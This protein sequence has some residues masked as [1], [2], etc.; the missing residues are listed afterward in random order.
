VNP[1]GSTVSGRGAA[2][3]RLFSAAAQPADLLIREAHVLDPRAQID[4][5][6]D[7]LIRGGEIAELAVAGT[8]EAPAGAE[9]IE[10]AG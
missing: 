9:T 4:G 2:P 8:L 3:A 1:A 5:R 6:H 7:V 10:A